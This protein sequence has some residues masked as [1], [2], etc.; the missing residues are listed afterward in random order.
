MSENNKEEIKGL[1]TQIEHLEDELKQEK[2]K[3][4]R[5]EMVH[6]RNCLIIYGMEEKDEETREVCH[7][8][9]TKMCNEK[10]EI[11]E[12][13]IDVCYRIGKKQ[14]DTG[15]GKTNKYT[16]PRPIWVRFTRQRTRDQIWF[17]RSKMAKSGI[18]LKEPLPESMEK[19]IK[20]LLPVLKEA[21]QQGKKANLYR[22]ILYIDD[23]RYSIEDMD[24]LPAE[25]QLE[26]VSTKTTKNEILFWGENAPLSNFYH[27]DCSFSDGEIRFNCVEQFYAH[28]R[29]RFFNDLEAQQKI[30]G[31]DN[32]IE[33]KR[34]RIKGFKKEAWHENAKEIMRKGLSLKFNQNPI[35]KKY[36]NDTG[37]KILVEANPHDKFWGIVLNTH[38]AMNTDKKLWGNNRLGVLLMELRKEIR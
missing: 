37:D 6:N 28:E 36:L 9:V 1:K 27:K 20:T 3:R 8:A 21:R 22:D 10:Y 19:S 34:T 30:L 12:P 32:P 26:N 18:V 15:Q 2:M 16:K 11:N 24:R 31:T 14:K 7:N 29:A 35:L 33:Q 38:E 25:L 17:Q 23:K 4:E 5:L 13:D